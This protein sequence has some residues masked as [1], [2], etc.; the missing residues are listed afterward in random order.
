V[1]PHGKKF[2][3]TKLHE[4]VFLGKLTVAQLFM[5]QSIFYGTPRSIMVFAKTQ[6]EVL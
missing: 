6:K 3:K 1:D 5:K 4:A 2:N